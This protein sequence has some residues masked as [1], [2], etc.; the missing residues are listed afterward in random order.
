SSSPASTRAA[1]VAAR[2]AKA[3]ARQTQHQISQGVEGK[4][5]T[6]SGSGGMFNQGQLVIAQPDG[7]NLTFSL[8]NQSHA[9]KTTGAGTAPVAESATGLPAGQIVVVRGIQ[10]QT[11]QYWAPVV[12]DSGYT[13]G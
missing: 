10:V 2:R 3:K 5:V 4:V 9:F 8:S 6:D 1:K 12:H 7:T 13:A 11:G